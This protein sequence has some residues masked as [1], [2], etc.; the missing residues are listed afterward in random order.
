[1]RGVL[2][3]VEIIKK[4]KFLR[5]RGFVISDIAKEVSISKSLVSKY[6]QGVSVLPE[7]KEKLKE[8]QGGSKFRSQAEW[9]HARSEAKSLIPEISQKEKMLILCALYWGEGTKRELNIINSDP[10][11]LRV[12]IECLRE[13]GISDKQFKA[14]IRIYEDLP[15]NKVVSFWSKKIGL[16]LSCFT[17]INVLDGKKNGKL[18]YGMCRIRVEKSAKYFKLIMSVIDRIKDIMSS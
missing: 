1:M 12:V 18:P 6:I 8:K 14:T 9:N 15:R 5:S 4:I 10:S 13:L 3:S 17:N 7:Y 11:M 16:P 2:T